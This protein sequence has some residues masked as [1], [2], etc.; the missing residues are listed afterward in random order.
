M[1]VFTTLWSLPSFP[2]PCLFLL[3]DFRHKANRVWHH[4]FGDC[5]RWEYRPTLS[6]SCDSVSVMLSLFLEFPT[7]KEGVM[8]RINMTALASV[9]LDQAEL[10]EFT[11]EV[12]VSAQVLCQVVCG[13][14][15]VGLHPTLDTWEVAEGLPPPCF[16]LPFRLPGLFLLFP[17]FSHKFG[18]VVSSRIVQVPA[19]LHFPTSSYAVPESFSFDVLPD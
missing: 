17:E 10:S 9:V 19:D 3:Q 18:S 5:V 15:P 14:D 6:K 7:Y 13:L 8:W 16:I 1:S 12:S 11:P 2:V 4:V